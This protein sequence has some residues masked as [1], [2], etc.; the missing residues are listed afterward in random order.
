MS[1]SH[2]ATL[3]SARTTATARATAPRAGWPWVVLLVLVLASLTWVLKGYQLFQGTMVLCYAIAL[4]GLNILTGYNGQISLGHGAFFALGAY[5]AAIA[6][7]HGG[8]PYWVAVPVAGLACL[9]VGYLFGRPALKLEG[10][11]LAL[12]T[13]ALAVAMPQLLK[14]KHL[15]QWTGG[16]G[17]IVLMK[18]D[19][20]FGLPLTQDQ[21]LFLYA[22]VVTVVMF[23]IGYNLLSSGSGRAMRAIRD[24]AMAAEAMG[25]DNPHYKSMTFGISAA[26]TGVGGALSAIAVQFVSPDSFTLF[27]SISLLVGVVVGGLGTLWGAAFGA[28]FIM[29]VPSFAESISKAAPWA[30][31]GVVLIVIMFAMPGGVVG[32][33][34]NTTARWKRRAAP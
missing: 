17:G 26:F 10:L 13:F 3:N 31:Y 19:A 16:V 29:F 20:P 11:Y 30:V 15:E 32:M 34:R 2:S 22:L 24:H 9:T 28:L 6:M 5:A 23:V 12:A 33:L 18:P 14:Y 21:W 25:V 7:E 27:L 8:L 1:S 4:L